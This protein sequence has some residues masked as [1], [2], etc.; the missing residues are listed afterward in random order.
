MGRGGSPV[1]KT[2]DVPQDSQQI[3]KQQD[4]VQPS[5]AHAPSMLATA[6]TTL[7]ASLLR[8]KLAN[9][10]QRKSDGGEQAQQAESKGAHTA[11]HDGHGSQSYADAGDHH[12]SIAEAL[13]TVHD[14]ATTRTE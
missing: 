9:R 2:V 8:R 3:P 13:D 12:G 7:G 14:T 10:I 11:S 5:E 4:Q 6:Q 1:G